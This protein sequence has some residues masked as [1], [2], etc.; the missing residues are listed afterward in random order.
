[1]LRR[2]L[3]LWWWGLFG[4]VCSV[5]L[6]LPVSDCWAVEPETDQS[7]VE[8]EP[9]G[10]KFVRITRDDNG[11]PL[12]LDTSIVRYQGQAPDGSTL[13]VDLVSAIHIADQS[14]YDQLNK[15][16]EQYDA[17]LYEMVAP[18]GTRIKRGE[19]RDGNFISMLQTGMK[20][21]LEL[22]SQLDQI[23]YEKENFVHADMSPEEFAQSMSNRN[24]NFWT[25]FARV[26]AQSMMQQSQNPERA[27]DVDLLRA[28]FEPN[29]AVT[30]K[31]VMAEQFENLETMMMAFEG[32]QGSTLISDRNQVAL[33]V[34]AEQIAAGHR[35]LGIFYGGG[36]MID[37][38]KR[39]IDEFGMEKV[40]ERWLVA[41]ELADDAERSE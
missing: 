40:S 29:R 28:L 31:R 30:L 34:L 21:M 17:L 4:S 37:M 18:R 35:K 12:T 25:L 26:M 10:T 39:L 22:D 15:E 27:N 7:T 38:E 9:S 19:R 24:E 41:W 5:G 36:H 8:A 6:G 33:G 23:D 11:E 1:M 14:Y 20:V 16:F 3:R 13:T 32:P 2:R